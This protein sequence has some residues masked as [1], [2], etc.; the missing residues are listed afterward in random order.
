M[1]EFKPGKY[2]HYK[3]GEYLLIGVGRHSET[4]EEFVVYQAHYDSEEFGNQAIWIRPKELFFQTIEWKG[5]KL[6]RFKFVE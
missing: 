2:R 6:P 5:Q 3:G 4:H 1:L